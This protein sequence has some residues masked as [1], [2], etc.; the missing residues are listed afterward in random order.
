MAS[1]WVLGDP[2]AFVVTQTP[3]EVEALV[4]DAEARGQVFLEL[5][6]SDVEDGE[7]DA[8]PWDGRPLRVRPER[9]NAIAPPVP[10]QPDP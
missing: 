5:T 7:G 9:I 10:R 6:L 4:E 1:V 8:C 3:A 2:T